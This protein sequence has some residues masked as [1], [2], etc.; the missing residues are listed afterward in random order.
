MYLTI[1]ILV[2]T[3]LITFFLGGIV[4]ISKSETI[5]DL[6]QR[7]GMFYLKFSDIPFS[8]ELEGIQQGLVS[9]GKKQGKWLEFWIAGQLKNKGEYN[10]GKKNGLWLLFYTNGQ[11]M[12]KGNYLEDREDV[13]WQ[14][15]LRD[16]TINQETSGNYKDG[17]KI[18]SK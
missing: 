12:G 14:Y 18:D 17:R 7:E 1:K 11:L 15:Y 2:F 16:G 5:D 4:S 10:N 13:E 8:G 3:L 9:E 6:V